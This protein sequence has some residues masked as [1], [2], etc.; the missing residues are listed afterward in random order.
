[1][2]RRPAGAASRGSGVTATVL[3]PGVVSTA[4]GAED[5]AAFVT[6][7]SPLIRPFMKT[8]GQGAATSIYLAA[9]PQVEGVTGRYFANSKPKKSSKSTAPRPAACGR[10]VSISSAPPPARETDQVSGGS[11]AAGLADCSG[12]R[13]HQPRKSGRKMRLS[14]ARP[15]I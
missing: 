8:T 3:H 4:F 11:A 9:S 5:Q 10:S 6:I 12:L 7:L 14:S 15:I 1:M 13:E 2:R